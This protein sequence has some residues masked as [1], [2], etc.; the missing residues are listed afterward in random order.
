M[1]SVTLDDLE[2]RNSPNRRV[3]SPNSVAFGADYVKVVEDTPVLLQ[4]KCRPQNL[5]FCRN[6]KFSDHNETKRH[7]QKRQ[8]HVLLMALIL[9]QIAT[10][11]TAH[12]DENTNER[13][14]RFLCLRHQLAVETLCFQAV[15]PLS[16]NTCFVWRD[17]SLHS[18]EISMK[19]V[20]CYKYLSREWESVKRSSTSLMAEAYISTVWRR[21]LLVLLLK[22]NVALMKRR[23]SLFRSTALC[24][25][26]RPRTG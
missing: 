2:R 17:I 15:R 5:V 14:R 4:R 16:V 10:W 22:S 6:R 9:C 18:G 25:A 1:N 7:K 13:T 11:P 24:N 8:H 21:G 20:S 3:I 23:W 12:D 19:L 26:A